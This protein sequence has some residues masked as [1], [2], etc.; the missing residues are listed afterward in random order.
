[1]GWEST[2]DFAA[3]EKGGWSDPS[4]AARYAADFARASDMAS[5][6]LAE[7]VAADE[8][9]EALDLCC[10]QGN[11]LA[12]LEA[13]GARATGL[14]F[15]PAMLKLTAEAC[16]N[17]RLVE[18]DA[19]AL[20][21]EDARFDAVTCGF[22]IMHVP[23]AE[24]ML[25][26]ARRVLKP[27]GRFAFSCWAP[28]AEGRPTALAWVFG[29]VETHGAEGSG[30]PPGPGIFDHAE[31]DRV[32][33]SFEAAGFSAPELDEVASGWTTDRADA[34]FVFFRDGTVR[35]GAMLRRQP[36]EN[37]EAIRAAV[38]AQVHAALGAAPP[39]QIPMPSRVIA[40]TAV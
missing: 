4:V 34:P 26:E 20:P 30:L 7:A 32:A 18:G 14:D 36:P 39:W 31:P 24:A 13:R 22:G 19:C 8:G 9:A 16:P 3:M 25:A 35:G 37:A 15:S 10:G 6:L 27:G 12:A 33:G 29:A 2:D 5:P 1:M 21:F 23:D 40:A 17:A 38:V 28:L 11:V